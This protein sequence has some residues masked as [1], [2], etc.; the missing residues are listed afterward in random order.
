M[1]LEKGEN[2]VDTEWKGRRILWNG[3]KGV[4]RERG[5]RKRPMCERKTGKGMEWSRS[6]C[7]G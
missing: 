5:E 6:E 1:R 4:K 3:R 7:K 2:G